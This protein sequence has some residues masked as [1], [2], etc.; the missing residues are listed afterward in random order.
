MAWTREMTLAKQRRRAER[1]RDLAEKQIALGKI[2][3]VYMHDPS[4]VWS[5]DDVAKDAVL[6]LRH[7]PDQALN[8]LHVMK[9]RGFT[10]KSCFAS[11]TDEDVPSGVDWIRGRHVLFLI[12]TRGNVP[13][14][15]MGTQFRSTISGPNAIHEVIGR[16][17]PKMPRRMVDAIAS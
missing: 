15:A 5:N 17:F 7:T 6:F 8:A 3:V 1:E 13:A 12:G 4:E 14:P 11:P 16:Y 9:Q 10:Y 2:G